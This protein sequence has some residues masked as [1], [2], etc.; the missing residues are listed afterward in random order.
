MLYSHTK[1]IVMEKSHTFDLKNLQLKC[2]KIHRLYVNELYNEND[3][4][5]QIIETKFESS[6][7]KQL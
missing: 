4:I 1:Q 3:I 2:T 6:F 7:S 5:T